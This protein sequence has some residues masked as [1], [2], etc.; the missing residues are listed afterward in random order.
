MEY[1]SSTQYHFL[2][3]LYDFR[4]VHTLD[5]VLRRFLKPGFV[6]C[7][8]GA[9]VGYYTLWMARLADEL[10]GHVYAFEP[11]PANVSQIRKN[12]ELN[13]LLN[14]VEVV[15]SVVADRT[16]T[17]EFLRGESMASGSLVLE[18]A[19]GSRTDT[20]QI[21]S[22]HVASTTL[23]DFF[24]NSVAP[25]SGPDFL[26]IDIEGAGRTALA[27]MTRCFA[28]SRPV[29]LGES[30]S[31][32]EDRAFGEMSRRHGYQ[33]FRFNNWSWVSNLSATYPSADGVWGTLLLV[34]GELANQVIPLLPRRARANRPPSPTVG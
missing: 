7:D 25:R 28:R 31:P 5:R 29:V 17:V 30:H 22:V 9:N 21:E 2:V 32:D 15:Q 33:A 14:R 13:D 11:E 20:C 6:A 4:I 10:E 12:L 27:E 23:D 3:G 18:W 24:F 19:R 16:G 1:S 26:K 34:P 8:L